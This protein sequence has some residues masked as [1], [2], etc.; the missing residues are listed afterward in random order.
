MGPG[1]DNL[2]YFELP[3][4]PAGVTYSLAVSQG[5]IDLLVVPEPSSFVLL[6]VGVVGLLAFARRRRRR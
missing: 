1:A 3:P 6:G 4:A 5:D 2:A